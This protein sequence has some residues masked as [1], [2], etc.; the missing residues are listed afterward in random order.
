MTNKAKETKKELKIS[1][2]EA[3]AK[4]TP[5]ENQL[6]DSQQ[7]WRESMARPTKFEHFEGGEYNIPDKTGNDEIDGALFLAK[8]ANQYGTQDQTAG[9]EFAKQLI[10]VAR[11]YGKSEDTVNAAISLVAQ[12][13][14]KD[15][16]EA[17]LVN[18]MVSVHL[19]T[20]ASAARVFVKGQ[21]I[22]GTSLYLREV[23][24][25]TRTFA[26]QMD[27]LNKHRGKGQQKMTVEH[28][29]VNEGGQAV[30]GNVEGSKQPGPQLGG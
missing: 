29:H 23:N 11:N 14:P 1:N 17:M 10:A 5:S 6:I 4:L 12:I 24:K 8:L 30:I 21:F 19:L 27:A 13:R 22:D 25:L 20:M 15:P 7:E 16:I 18:Q 3:L 28:I 26:A 2:K 9:L